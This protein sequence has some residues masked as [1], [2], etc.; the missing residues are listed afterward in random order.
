M[1]LPAK[2]RIVIHLHY[3]E[4]YTGAEIGEMLGIKPSA[5]SM[6]LHR[7]RTMLRS[8]LQEESYEK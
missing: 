4:G 1:A 5:V 3:Y 6:R 8:V 2:Y 7:A